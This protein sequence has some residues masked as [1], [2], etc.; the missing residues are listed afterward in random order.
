MPLAGAF[1][2]GR[3]SRC[4][5]CKLK[6][7][8]DAADMWDIE[9][10]VKKKLSPAPAMRSLRAQSPPAKST[11]SK[12]TMNKS[13]DKDKDKDKEK[14]QERGNDKNR[15]NKDR[16]RSRADKEVVAVAEKKQEMLKFRVPPKF[17]I[18]CHT[19]E[20]DYACVICCGPRGDYSGVVLLCDDPES[21]VDHVAKEHKVVEIEREVDILPG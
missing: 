16:S 4:P 17:V 8:V 21:L 3:G 18:K 14:D 10:P 11:A 1:D 20:G 13:K 12:K 2:P 5:V 19:P 15:D 9:F 7:P 6:I